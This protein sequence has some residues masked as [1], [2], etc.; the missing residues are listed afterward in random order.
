L[1]V[2]FQDGE[3]QIL[4]ISR[5][6]IVKVLDGFPASVD[7][8][9]LL[10]NG[11]EFLSFHRFYNQDLLQVWDLA[12]GRKKDTTDLSPY[13][14]TYDSKI[15]FSPD[16]A[17]MAVGTKNLQL[18]DF[19]NKKVIGN[20]KGDDKP[21]SEISDIAFSP[22]GN[23]I[24][25][26]FTYGGVRLATTSGDV[27]QSL[28]DARAWAEL[29]LFKDEQILASNNQFWDLERG[30]VVKTLSGPYGSFFF[31][32]GC[33]YFAAMAEEGYFRVRR[34]T[35]EALGERVGDFDLRAKGIY[36][37]APAAFS[38]D[39]ELVAVQ[40]AIGRIR[41]FSLKTM[42]TVAILDGHRDTITSLNFSLDGKYLISSS[43]D[44]TIRVWGIHP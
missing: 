30:K 35:D 11:S 26:S 7:D 39:R 31:T 24:A 10:S 4:D 13:G 5:D 36:L 22:D 8:I 21:Y 40:E 17:L 37:I 12:E 19:R 28:D 9:Q 16:G 34:N 27:I 2:S 14:V 29:C 32:P 6:E 25:Y 18:W 43:M 42:D 3:I 33:D 23:S 20:L 15:I 44:G 38:P 41:V 1:A